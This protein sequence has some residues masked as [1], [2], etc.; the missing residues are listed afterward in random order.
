MI[1]RL[2]IYI[3]V[4][5][6]YT[7]QVHCKQQWW[8]WPAW[9]QKCDSQSNRLLPGRK[10]NISAFKTVQSLRILG[11]KSNLAHHSHNDRCQALPKI[12]HMSKCFNLSR[13]VF[14]NSFE[15]HRTWTRWCRTSRVFSITWSASSPQG[16]HIK[17]A[18]KPWGKKTHQD[19]SN[20]VHCTSLKLL[21]PKWQRYFSI[22]WASVG[23]HE[24][25]SSSLSLGQ[26]PATFQNTSGEIKMRL[27]LTN[28]N[29][30]M[31]ERE[32][33]QWGW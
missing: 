3:C 10:W 8:T 12:K 9:R 23:L 5:I 19:P 15:R 30:T 32:T 17:T 33:T 13:A 22:M 7:V 21:C 25:T 2:Y 26:V 24:P 31:L 20:T 28:Y 4:N 6:V 16:W 29:P 14:R 18:D 1:I 11:S 27:Q